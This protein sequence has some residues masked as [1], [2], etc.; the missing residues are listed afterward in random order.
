MIPVVKFY[1]SITNK[2]YD[3][4]DEAT[5]AENEIKHA[6]EKREE[7]RTN[8]IEE[9]REYQQQVKEMK[10]E[11]D[12]AYKSYAELQRSYAKKLQ[13]YYQE[14]GYYPKEFNDLNSLTMFFLQ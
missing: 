1:S 10:K 6:Q 3:S 4:L 11:S 2:Y 5:A 13:E 12:K 14:Y 9:L 7:T 8:A